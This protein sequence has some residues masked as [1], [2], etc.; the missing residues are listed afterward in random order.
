[1][2]TKHLFWGFLFITLGTL[3]LINNF[4]SL[5]FYWLSIW[6][7]WPL[8]LILIGI[9]LLIKQET[10]RAILISLTAIVLGAAIFSTFKLGW[11]YFRNEVII[12]GG[13]GIEITDE[14]KNFETKVFE[15]SYKEN[16]KYASLHFEAG[17]GSFKI[18]DT[19][20]SLFYAISKGYDNNYTL[21]RS[22]EGENVK[23]H[24]EN[25]KEGFFIFRGK[26]KNRVN[27]NLNTNPVWKMKFDIGAAATEFDLRQFKVEDLDIDIGAASLEIVLGDLLDSAKVEINAGASSIE[28]SIPENVGC[29]VNADIVLSKREFEGFNKTRD[30]LYRTE[31]FESSAKKIYMNIDTGVSSVKIK[32]FANSEW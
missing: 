2:K 23:L 10:V 16:I 27:I 8:F 17:A 5:D 6:Q 22:D 24:F 19:T 32:R 1:M 7:F 28:I 15:E 12:D 3:I 30:D 21:T 29:E 20:S 18:T 26:N 13:N 9:S 31:N 11:G 25:K 4:T 14:D